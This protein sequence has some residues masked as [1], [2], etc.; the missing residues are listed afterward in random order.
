MVIHT[1]C[2]ER[3]LILSSNT[4]AV[5]VVECGQC[6]E[7]TFSASNRGFGC[8]VIRGKPRPFIPSFPHDPYAP[9]STHPFHKAHPQIVEKE[10]IFL[11]VYPFKKLWFL[12]RA[13]GIRPYKE[14]R[15]KKRPSYTILFFTSS[16]TEANELSP[17][18][19]SSTRLQALIAVVWSFL[20]NRVLMRL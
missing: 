16:S 5:A 7:R 20:S 13:D 2:R 17:S 3:V 14:S 1:P 9:Q 12:S 18:I 10:R 8:G 15:M 11:I 6:G 19:I 4:E